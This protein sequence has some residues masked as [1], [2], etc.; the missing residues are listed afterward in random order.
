[1]LVLHAGPHKTATTYIQQNLQRD[2]TVLEGWGWLY[3]DLGTDGM[4]AHHDLAHNSGRY[5]GEG[6]EHRPELAK[7]A[8]S[9]AAMG[10]NVVLSAEGFCRWGR[11]KFELIADVFGQDVIDVIYVIRDPLD[12]F[13]SYWAEE[14]KQGYTVSLA[15]RFAENFNDP[16]ASR[17]LNPMVDLAPLLRSAR[18]RIHAVPFE[19]L[20]ARDIDIYEH[21]CGSVLG[22]ERVK[23]RATQRKNTSFP[24]ELTEFLRLLTLMKSGDQPFIGSGFRHRFMAETSPRERDQFAELV[25]INGKAARR[26]IT[27]GASLH[28]KRRLDAV[29][30]EHLAGNWSTDIGDDDLFRKR[31]QEF[32]YYNEYLMWKNDAIRDAAAELLTRIKD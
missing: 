23:A 21:V 28:H 26:T 9:A 7:L 4:P 13:H 12:I 31:D 29:L 22:L 27:F 8:E 14:I 30:R 32:V 20:R 16:M 6:G 5:I 10:Q 11:R 3:P 25:R 1:M 19:I 2:R 24:I 18:I 15:E 17:L